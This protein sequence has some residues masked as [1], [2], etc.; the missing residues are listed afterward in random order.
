MEKVLMVL[1]PSYLKDNGIGVIYQEFDLVNELSVAENIFLGQP[2]RKGWVIDSKQMNDKT[3]EL[4]DEF[5]IDINPDTLVKNLSVGYQQLVEIA[6]AISRE[7]KILIMDEPSAPLTTSEVST[8]FSIIHKLR[9]AGVTIIYIS[10]RL[11]EIFEISD[12]VS[13]LRDG[14]LLQTMETKNTNREELVRLMVGRELKETF[15]IRTVQKN[16]ETLLE[17]KNICGNGLKNISFQLKK[18]EILGLGGLVGAGRTEL[19]QVLFGI[20]NG[21]KGEI[22]YRGRKISIKNPREAI[23]H[24]NI[25]CSRRQKTAG[26]FAAFVRCGKHNPSMPEKVIKIFGYR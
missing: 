26:S 22:I 19:A 2:I 5:G 25:A 11:E 21:I 15:P 17:M 14:E 3:K 6:K 16:S 20:A 1:P 8:M 7:T 24:G 18:G 23:A 13:V 9:A 12:Y 10:H 4:F